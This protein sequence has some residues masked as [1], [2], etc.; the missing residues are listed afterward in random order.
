MRG[1]PFV[2]CPEHSQADHIVWSNHGFFRSSEVPSADRYLFFLYLRVHSGFPASGTPQT[3][4]L[5]T[6]KPGRS[7][8]VRER[9]AQESKR[10]GRLDEAQVPR[11]QLCKYPYGVV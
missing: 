8:V 6:R 11:C 2:L 10:A 1:A 3:W 9:A 7:G 5:W 4:A